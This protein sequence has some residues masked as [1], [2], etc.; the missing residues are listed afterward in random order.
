MSEGDQNHA[1]VAMPVTIVTGRLDQPLD[2]PLIE[3][4]A[5]AQLLVW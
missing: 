4:L 5:R 2:L 3:V 1:A